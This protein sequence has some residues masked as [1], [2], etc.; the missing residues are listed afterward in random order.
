MEQTAPQTAPQTAAQSSKNTH[1]LNDKFPQHPNWDIRVLEQV[2]LYSV[3]YHVKK[4]EDIL[5]IP[6][7]FHSTIADANSVTG[8]SKQQYQNGELGT[9][10]SMLP[11]MLMTNI[12]T[13]FK[14]IMQPTAQFPLAFAYDAE[15]ITKCSPDV[16]TKENFSVLPYLID[17]AYERLIHN[18][19]Y[20]E[21]FPLDYTEG[22]DY[23]LYDDFKFQSSAI[24]AIANLNLE[25]I[26]ISLQGQLTL[27][28]EVFNSQLRYGQFLR[29]GMDYPTLMNKDVRELSLSDLFAYVS[30][31]KDVYDI[32]VIQVEDIKID[33]KPRFSPSERIAENK[34]NHNREGVQF[35]VLNNEGALNMGI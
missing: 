29:K 12:Y 20:K 2:S 11:V 10:Y 4:T 34:L 16:I 8:V 3:N 21:L 26:S 32:Q 14:E 13:M 35:E 31:N 6:I 1:F 17:Y 9:T 18:G 27:F 28:T 5:S 23:F 22:K 24:D 33:G 25:E 30:K 19:I 7:K 15:T